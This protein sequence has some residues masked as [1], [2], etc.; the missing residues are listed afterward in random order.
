MVRILVL[1][2]LLLTLVGTGDHVGTSVSNWE[3]SQ[4]LRI[5]KTDVWL[6]E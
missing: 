6:H 2:V 3:R 4:Q 1:Y 5:L